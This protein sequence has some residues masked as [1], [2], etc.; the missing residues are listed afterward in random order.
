MILKKAN[1]IEI[2]PTYDGTKATVYKHVE[3]CGRIC[4][5]SEDRISDGSAD[6]FVNML[7]DKG[8]T[9]MI[10]HGTLY[11]TITA[12]RFGRPVPEDILIY[13]TEFFS[14]N[15][16]ST[17]NYT[18]DGVFDISKTIY[19]TTNMRVLEDNPLLK[20]NL[21]HYSIPLYNPPTEHHEKRRTFLI[22]CD[23]GVSHELVRH[24]VFSFAQVSQRYV[25]YAKAKFGGQI[26][27]IIPNWLSL[28]EGDYNY[29]DSGFSFKFNTPVG[30]RCSSSLCEEFGEGAENW[31]LAMY[32]AERSYM[33]APQSWTPQMSRSMLP[34]STMTEIVMTGTEDQW[35]EFLKLRRD[36]AAHPQMREIAEMIEF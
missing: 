14:R 12:D 2:T 26:T 29:L 1:A 32:Y 24:R 27:Y 34:N 5:K 35:G 15:P 17:L 7:I 16:Y 36:A 9:A 11:L 6:K 33:R 30:V 10:E 22:T 13:F 21:L 31:L 28:P 20:L 23:R 18:I 3:R 25:N 19:V 4:Y 8:H